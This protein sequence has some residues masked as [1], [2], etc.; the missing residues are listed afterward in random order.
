VIGVGTLISTPMRYVG[1]SVSVS[2][3]WKEKP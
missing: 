2:V 3:N 1:M